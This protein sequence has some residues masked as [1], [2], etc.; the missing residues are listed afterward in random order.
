[1]KRRMLLLFPAALIL[2]GLLLW[3]S[4]V[5]R[6]VDR[7]D[8]PNGA[9]RA[10]VSEKEV[11]GAPAVVVELRGTHSGTVSYLHT[12]YEGL[13]WSPDSSKYLVEMTPLTADGIALELSDLERN[14]GTN[15]ASV[16]AVAMERTA[17]ADY[18]FRMD[19]TATPVV[20]L[21]FRQWREDSGAIQFGYGFTDT[22]GREHRGD[23]WYVLP[24][25][26]GRFAY[27]SGSITDIR[28]E[29]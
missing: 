23:F 5:F 18:G 9:L 19:E 24:T 21:T 15:L 6:V 7:V 16:V 17:L 25:E 11:E 26:E 1:M 4:G 29:E 27:L 28:E 12:A 10:T 2:A 14:A 22:A 20:D 13:W 3:H 8:A